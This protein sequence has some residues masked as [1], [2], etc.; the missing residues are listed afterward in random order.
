MAAQV[1]LYFENQE[2]ALRFTLAAGS[3]LAASTSEPEPTR[4]L[5]QLRKV[6]R[7]IGH[8]TRITAGSPPET[9]DAAAAGA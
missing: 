5:E 4:N 8:A 2:D 3:V 7:E 6:A 1:V 9:A